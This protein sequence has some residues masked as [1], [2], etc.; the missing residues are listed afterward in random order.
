MKN[1]SLLITVAA[2]AAVILFLAI[3][4]QRSLVN[5]DEDVKEKWGEV[6]NNYQRRSDLIP[7]LVNIVKGATE[8]EK[9][10]LVELTEARSKAGS[11]EVSEPTAENYEQLT[12]AQNNVTNSMNK[13][14]A[15]VENYP[16]LKATNQF[17]TLQAQ[18][19]GTERRVKIARKDFNESVLKYNQKVRQFPASIF[20][21]MFGFKNKE[22]FRADAGAEKV[23]EV[24]FK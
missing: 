7:S 8:Y 24:S 15:V 2:I 16:D 21:G 4:S 14:I 5:L 6:Q 19:E 1:K 11:I 18:L 17:I 9:R 3:P 22:G 10:T 12:N 23:P 13:V 20:A